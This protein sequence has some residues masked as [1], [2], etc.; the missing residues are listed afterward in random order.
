MNFGRDAR[1]LVF[2][3]VAVPLIGVLM[4]LIIPRIM[5]AF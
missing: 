1:W 3:A 2:L 4:A 5:R